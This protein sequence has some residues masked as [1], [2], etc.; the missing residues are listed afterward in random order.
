LRDIPHPEHW[1]PAMSQGNDFANYASSVEDRG[2]ASEDVWFVAVSSDDIKQMT[3]DQLD[4][5]FRLGVITA[6]TAVWTEGMEAWAP[7]GEV[8]DLD[9]DE[10]SSE[11][12]SSAA[13]PGAL[14]AEA[15]PS[16]SSESAPS[17]R[18]T[19]P[20]WHNPFDP[21]GSVAPAASNGMA[22]GTSIF[23]EPAPAHR[24]VS[25]GPSSFAPVTA[26]YAP[27]AGGAL[28]HSTGPVAL[29]V[30]EDSPPIAR[31]RRFRPERWL[32]AAAG[33][34]AVGV[35]AVN[36]SDLFSAS[37]SVA[38]AEKQASAAALVAHPYVAPADKA[39]AK[40]AEAAAEKAAEKDDGKDAPIGSLKG[41]AGEEDNGGAAPSAAT[42]DPVTKPSSK[43]KDVASSKDALHEGFAKAFSKAP[44]KESKHEKPA[45]AA[46]AT[47][48]SK[49]SHGKT[50][51][52]AA[53]ASASS[54]SKK[55][56][57][58]KSGSAFDP[59]NGSLP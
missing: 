2:S 17:H 15:A 14:A 8:A 27:P 46:K 34:I 23:S 49:M 19:N 26:S 54:K 53:S 13:A 6:Q 41:E 20:G 7:L 12:E 16:S 32:L 44:G 55:P 31:G 4:E 40:G 47:K 36:N 22:S 38:A 35:I 59:L 51:S 1:K 21:P 33:V 43:D 11:S 58:P 29:N 24:S 5:A 39:G 30:D 9:G 57:A 48:A 50:P 25:M 18:R 45:K 37:K 10:S 28:N 52:R 56:G 42:P 3:I